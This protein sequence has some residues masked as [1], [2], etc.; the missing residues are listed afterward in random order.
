MAAIS[1]S[2]CQTNSGSRS[3]DQSSSCS[4]LC[5]RA[6]YAAHQWSD[7]HRLHS[8]SKHQR[9]QVL[10]RYPVSG[11]CPQVLLVLF[12]VLFWFHCLFLSFQSPTSCPPGFLPLQL[13]ALPHICVT[14]VQLSLISWRI[15]SLCQLV[16]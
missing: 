8:R 1:V 3:G 14:C 11:L 5:R 6:S 2:V 13:A 4:V 9:Q 15:W 7:S 12:P 10:Q 16:F